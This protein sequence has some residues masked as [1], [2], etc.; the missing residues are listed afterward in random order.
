VSEIEAMKIHGHDLAADRLMKL[1][2]VVER[3]AQ[4][5]LRSFA[6]TV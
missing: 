5:R 3:F 6:R 1:H 2:G 4:V